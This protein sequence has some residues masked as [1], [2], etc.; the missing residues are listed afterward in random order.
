MKVCVDLK[1]GMCEVVC[2][3]VI[4]M[5]DVLIKIFKP[6]LHQFVPVF[7]FYNTSNNWSHHTCALS[8]IVFHILDNYYDE[9][10]YTKSFIKILLHFLNVRSIQF[11]KWYFFKISIDKQNSPKSRTRTCDLWE[12]GW[13]FQPNLSHRS[14]TE[15]PSDWSYKE[16][17][18]SNFQ[19]RCV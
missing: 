16:K 13:I 18:I 11:E 19:L 15:L 1:N 4:W 8:V 9:P 5:G 10:S 7:L 14:T 2:K 3:C 12:Q 17:I 6:N